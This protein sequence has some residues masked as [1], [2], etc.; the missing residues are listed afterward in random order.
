M[1]RESEFSEIQME[2][3][4]KNIILEES[5]DRPKVGLTVMPGFFIGTSF[6]QSQVYLSDVRVLTEDASVTR[7]D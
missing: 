1:K 6:V 7:E 4:V 3:A 2:S 5:E